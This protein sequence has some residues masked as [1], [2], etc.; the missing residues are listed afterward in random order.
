[1][2]SALGGMTVSCLRKNTSFSDVKNRRKKM[3]AWIWGFHSFFWTSHFYPNI[4]F[5]PLSKWIV[6]IP[7][8]KAFVV[9]VHVSIFLFFLEFEHWN[10]YLMQKSSFSFMH[11]IEDWFQREK[12]YDE[13]IRKQKKRCKKNKIKK[14]VEEKKKI[15][16][17]L[18]SWSI[19][20][21]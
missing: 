21:A 16:F 19:L 18:T 3:Y 9:Q 10:L 2:C 6:F 8:K 20:I 5:L 4:R 13:K 15:A 12:I 17:F 7:K 14:N 11:E 1:M